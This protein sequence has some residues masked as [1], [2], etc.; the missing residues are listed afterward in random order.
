MANSLDAIYPPSADNVQSFEK[1][2]ANTTQ[3]NFGSLLLNPKSLNVSGS[4]YDDDIN[5]S[6]ITD[7]TLRRAIQEVND[8]SRKYQPES[9]KTQLLG[10]INKVAQRHGIDEKLVQAV[11]KQ[12]SGFN[13][14]A[15]SRT[16]AMG[17]MQLM[18]STAKSLGVND[19]YNAAQNVDGGVR[20]LKSMLNKY[21]G[22]I[23]LALAAYNAG[24]GAVDKYSGVPPYKETQNYVKNI[25]ANYL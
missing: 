20:Y 9:N 22:N 14:N 19:P 4:I 11:I 8:A 24:P 1:I 10:M 25:L 5:T 21:N 2:L 23:I 12:E 15:T 16:G 17:L 18:P 13:P 7:A 3:T 6:G